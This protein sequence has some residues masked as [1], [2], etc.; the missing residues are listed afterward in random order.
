MLQKGVMACRSLAEASAW[1]Q[2]SIPVLGLRKVK[3]DRGMTEE[4][5]LRHQKDGIYL[6]RHSGM[7]QEGDEVDHVVA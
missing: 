5:W 6:V 1:V 3:V 7:K 4:E 2:D